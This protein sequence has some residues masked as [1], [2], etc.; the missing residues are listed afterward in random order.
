[1]GVLRPVIVLPKDGVESEV[2]LAHEAAHIEHQDLA[3]VGVYRLFQ[4]VFGLLPFAHLLVRE[5]AFWQEVRADETAIRCTG[6]SPSQL[7]H[8]ILAHCRAP[9]LGAMLPISGTTDD[10]RRRLEMLFDARRSGW[11]ASLA[12]ALALV[13]SWPNASPVAAN[14]TPEPAPTAVATMIR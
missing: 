7:A 4:G 13:A 11:Q 5:L 8:T 10:L 2:A 14:S 12:L 6:H 3:Y 9:S 1:M